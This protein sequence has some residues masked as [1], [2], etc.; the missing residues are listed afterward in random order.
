MNIVFAGT[1]NFAVPNLE[2]LVT[3]G[4]QVSR[5]LTQPDRP[6]G[7]GRKVQFSAVKQAALEHD[8]D[9]FQPQKMDAEAIELLTDL[10]PDLMVVV[11]YGIILPQRALEVPRLGCI[12]VHASLLPRWRGAAPIQRAI[13]AGD[14]QTGVCI[15]QMDAGLDTGDVLLRRSVPISSRDTSQSLHDTLASL[16]AEAL[17]ECVT[18]LHDGSAQHEPQ[19]G[20]DTTY[21]TRL[22]KSEAEINWS[23][24]ATEIDRRVRA[25][26]PWPVTFTQL[27]DETIRIW[28]TSVVGE[29]SGAA[30]GTIIN[31]HAEGI[32]VACGQGSLRVHIVQAPGKRAMAAIDFARSRSLEGM[33][34]ASHADE[35][36]K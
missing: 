20:C 15:M 6:A 3:Q 30:P 5:V 29:H 32:D 21:A 23:Q 4:H 24:S 9:V 13:E 8:L 36:A 34:L 2:A 28:E 25:F 11:A 12:N 16:G 35:T 1:P 33:V 19:D 22:S 27:G 7:R 14:A 26:N 10:Q 17:L 31:C 18:Q